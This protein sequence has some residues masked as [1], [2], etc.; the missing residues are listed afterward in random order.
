MRDDNQVFTRAAKSPAGVRFTYLD[1]LRGV[2]S[3]AVMLW[4]HFLAFFPGSVSPDIP[5]H[6]RLLE[7]YLYR[8]PL[9]IF[10]A[11]DFAVYIFFVLSGFVLTYRY[12][13][14]A[15]PAELNRSFFRRFIR[16]MPPAAVSIFV[17]Y[18]ILKSGLM[19]NNEAEAISGSPWLTL[20]WSQTEVTLRNAIWM[21]FYGMWFNGVTAQAQ[22]NSNLGTLALELMGSWMIFGII[23]IMHVNKLDVTKRYWSYFVIII[24]SLAL[25]PNDPHYLVFFAG[26]ALADIYANSG[27]LFKKLERYSYLILALGIYL[28]TVNTGNLGHAPYHT[29]EKIFRALGLHPLSYP[30]CLGAIVMLV[31]VLTNA[32]LKRLLNSNICQTLGHYSFALFIAHTVFLGSVT[33]GVFVAMMKID[34]IGYRTAIGL[35][36]III[37]PFL[38]LFTHFI[39]R[40]DDW[41]IRKSRLFG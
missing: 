18:I 12:F 41:A 37:L 13:A 8:S 28:A 26:M 7:K 16:L 6:S 24:V 9:N 29:L 15:D 2:A 30:W 10:F 4:H 23:L 39:K 20:N 22:F 17:S 14:G 3:V 33:S 38:A 1:G 27:H 25:D 21:S 31:G 5:M 34:G 11:G 19:F 32:P 35:T 36:F 40:V